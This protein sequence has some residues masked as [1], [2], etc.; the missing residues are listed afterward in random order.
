MNTKIIRQTEVRELGARKFGKGIKKIKMNGD[1]GLLSTV[2]IK[3][4]LGK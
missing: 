2:N 1:N 4:C 3:F